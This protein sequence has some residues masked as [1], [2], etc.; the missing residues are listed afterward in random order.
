MAGIRNTRTAAFTVAIILTAITPV[1]L[2]QTAR[3]PRQNLRGMVESRLQ[4][5][6]IRRG[7]D[8]ATP[9]GS[10][11]QRTIR[12]GSH[13]EVFSCKNFA[14]TIDSI[15]L[16]SYDSFRNANKLQ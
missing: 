14:K 9:P 10:E 12:V 5:A 11:A 2:G 16:P 4:P 13:V 1:V 8:F 7:N 6:P 3:I 15:I